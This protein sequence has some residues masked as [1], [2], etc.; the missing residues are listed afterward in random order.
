[1]N[2]GDRV[3]LIHGTEEGVITKLRSG[4]YLEIDIGDGFSIP[5]L[6]RE[7][8]LISPV[9][10][11]RMRRPAP[12]NPDAINTPTRPPSAFA[13]NGLFLAFI[14]QND[15]EFHLYFINNTDWRILFTM[16]GSR[17]G[18][19]KSLA[20]GV[21][22]ARK[23]QRITS[24]FLKDFEQW[25]VFE[26]AVLYF[27]EHRIPR[28]PV[29]RHQLRCRIQSFYK[30]QQTTPVVN[31]SGHV[32]QLDTTGTAGE[33]PLKITPE[34]LREGMLSPVPVSPALPAG[35]T[36]SVIDLHIEKLQGDFQQLSSA[37]IL[38]LQLHTFERYLEH[39][40]AGG[41]D[42]ITFV[43]GV[44]QGKLRQEIHQ[45][46]SRHPNIAFYKDAQ[47]EKFGYGATLA[48]LK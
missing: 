7:V 31:Q 48:H 46:L 1:M 9:E 21:L 19:V 17:E 27:S 26:T 15:R 18:L 5:V 10:A 32:Y 36:P 20:S 29:F 34:A 13:E 12:E 16:H 40:I 35:K 41:M 43:H 24:L 3:R 45:R 28:E 25:P 39:A 11:E 23:S 38:E 22:D 47:K 14:P 42:E 6:A 30:Q 2:I 4:N 8:V 37:Q 44:G 33:A